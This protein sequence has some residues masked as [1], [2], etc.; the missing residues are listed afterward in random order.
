MRRRDR[1][2]PSENF[3][4]PTGLTQR[5]IRIGSQAATMC[6]ISHRI[7]WVLPT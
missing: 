7:P 3:S 2:R 5:T 1:L 6:S 4:F